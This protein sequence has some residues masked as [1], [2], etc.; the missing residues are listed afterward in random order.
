MGPVKAGEGKKRPGERM[1]GSRGK[2]KRKP[3]RRKRV[4]KKRGGA[5]SEEQ[6]REGAGS[7]VDSP[8]GE[9]VMN[10]GNPLRV[11]AEGNREGEG[12]EEEER[13]R[14]LPSP[15]CDVDIM[16]D[17]ESDDWVLRNSER[18]N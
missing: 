1:E 3:R 4:K 5:E 9:G 17:R 2:R 12:G 7:E 16:Q 10:G 14:V 11:N 8:R 18:R 6:D 13:V 15:G